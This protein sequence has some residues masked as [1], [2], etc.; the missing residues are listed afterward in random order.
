MRGAWAFGGR[1]Y[2][3]W[4]LH[5][6]ERV[7]QQKT[8]FHMTKSSLSRK[9]NRSYFWDENERQYKHKKPS[10]YVGSLWNWSFINL[11]MVIVQI[12]QYVNV[13][14]PFWRWRI[15]VDT[16]IWCSKFCGVHSGISNPSWNSIN[17][18]SITMLESEFDP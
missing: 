17:P 11:I 6:N 18:N 1:G 4:Y 14:S 12:S 3:N 2:L 7:D 16:I 9:I 5:I 8:F 15:P 10:S 13:L